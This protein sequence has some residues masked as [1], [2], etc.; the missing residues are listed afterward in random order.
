VHG[1]KLND[2]PVHTVP[3]QEWVDVGKVVEDQKAARPNLGNGHFGI[4]QD[5]WIRMIGVDVNPIDTVIRQI[6]ETL[7]RAPR[8]SCDTAVV[9]HGL[10]QFGE[11]EVDEVQFYR[12]AHAEDA[13]CESARIRPDLN[14]APTFWQLPQEAVAR[15]AHPTVRK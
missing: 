2:G 12:L 13:R 15:C 9:R 14:D 11:I 4:P 5:S 10:A 3:T 6:G 8:M 7:V 1:R